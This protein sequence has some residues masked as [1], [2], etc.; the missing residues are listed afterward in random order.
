MF[1]SKTQFPFHIKRFI[2]G[3]H[4]EAVVIPS[5]RTCL[6]CRLNCFASSGCMYASCLWWRTTNTRRKE[7]PSGA[8]L[9]LSAVLLAIWQAVKNRQDPL[10]TSEI[11]PQRR[12]LGNIIL[13]TVTL[14]SRSGRI[15]PSL[16]NSVLLLCCFF[17]VCVRSLEI[18]PDFTVI[19]ASK[20]RISPKKSQI[21][22]IL[23]VFAF[24]FKSADAV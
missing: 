2:T 3:V 21:G 23:H 1:G 22:L 7:F 12:D 5:G 18:W 15:F 6:W 4:V 9:L 13:F 8:L 17:D 14:W 11:R 20:G 16:W 10:P 24:W 19:T